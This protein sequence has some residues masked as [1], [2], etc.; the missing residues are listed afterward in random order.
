MALVQPDVRDDGSGRHAG[1][2]DTALLRAA[3]RQRQVLLAEPALPVCIMNEVDAA[4]ICFL[5]AHQQRLQGHAGAHRDHLAH[6]TVARP[7]AD[8]GVVA[9]QQFQLAGV[10]LA[11]AADAVD[12]HAGRAVRVQGHASAVCRPAPPVRAAP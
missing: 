11:E 1:Q 2:H 3:D 5:A 9:R 6:I 4:Q 10:E 12:H 7:A 8:D